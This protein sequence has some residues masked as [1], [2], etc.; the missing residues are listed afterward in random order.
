MKKTVA[1]LIVLTVSVF[2][3]FAQGS[4]DDGPYAGVTNK[5]YKPM[6]VNYY[7]GLDYGLFVNPA[8]FAT[9]RFRVQA[10]TIDSSSF[11]LANALQNRSVAEA[12]SNITKFQ[13]D[14]KTWANYIMG[15]AFEVGSGYNDIVAGNFAMGVQ[16]GNF[17]FG[18]NATADVKS[19]P[20]IDE[21]GDIE[22]GKR[23]VLGNGYL[24]VVDAAVSVGYGR[25]VMDNGVITIDVGAT[26]HVAEKLYM[27]QLNYDEVVQLINKTKT[28]DDLTSRGGLALPIDI[29]ATLGLRDGMAKFSL[30]VNNINGYY[31][32]KAYDNFKNA[33]TMKDGTGAY[34][35]YTPW[36]VNA[37]AVFNLGIPVVTPT[38]GVEFSDIKGYF[39]N[40]MGKDNPGLELF[41]YLNLSANINASDIVNLRIAYKYGYPEFGI[42]AGYYGNTLE[43]IYGYHEAGKTYGEKPVDQLTFRIKLG[44]AK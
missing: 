13:W 43:L 10:L 41:K 32:M 12:L 29:G 16:I 11:N 26:V 6:D 31:Y 35:L 39:V 17:A 20:R 5:A 30:S 28:F 1:L 40:E 33:A 2:M 22:I 27:L 23:S 25:R 21:D 34:L 8:D 3:V 7:D 24:P 9:S 37:S 19:M 15:L 36:T 14:T 38:I 4:Y 18:V 44:Y 42:S